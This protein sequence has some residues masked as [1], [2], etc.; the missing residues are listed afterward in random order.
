MADGLEK[1]EAAE[2]RRFGQTRP[3]LAAA[4]L[5]LEAIPGKLHTFSPETG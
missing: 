3:S 5:L 1:P 2:R 4:R